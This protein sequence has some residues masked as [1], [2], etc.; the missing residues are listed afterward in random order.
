MWRF[1]L[2]LYLR[3]DLGNFASENDVTDLSKLQ[4]HLQ[5]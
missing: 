2:G 5:K 1:L 4:M 3:I